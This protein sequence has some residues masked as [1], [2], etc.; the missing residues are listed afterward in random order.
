MMRT[1]SAKVFRDHLY[2]ISFSYDVYRLHLNDLRGNPE[3][4]TSRVLSMR[5]IDDCLM[6]SR[7]GYKTFHD[8]GIGYRANYIYRWQNTIYLIHEKG[9]SVDGIPLCSFNGDD[10]LKV[11]AVNEQVLVDAHSGSYLFDCDTHTCRYIQTPAVLGP[12]SDHLWH[13]V[14]SQLFVYV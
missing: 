13:Q 5:V 10:I 2:Y 1:N 11:F 14:G 7:Y 8:S 3:K 12:Q 4:Y 9:I 6:F